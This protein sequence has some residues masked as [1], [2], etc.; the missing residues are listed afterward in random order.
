[1]PECGTFTESVPDGNFRDGVHI[2]VPAQKYHPVFRGQGAQKGV[3]EHS[4]LLSVPLPLP[5]G[6]RDAQLHFLGQTDHLSLALGGVL[7]VQPVQGEIPADFGKIGEKMLGSAGRNRIPGFQI[8][9]ADAF[10]R[11]LTAAQ[12]AVCQ[13]V[14][15]PSVGVVGVT[16]GVLIPGQ[17]QRNDLHV[18]HRGSPHSF[19]VPH[20]NRRIPKGKTHTQ[21]KNMDYF[22]IISHFTGKRKGVPA[23][24]QPR[25]SSWGAPWAFRTDYDILYESGAV[26]RKCCCSIFMPLK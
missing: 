20:P 4:Q 14:Q 24:E 1:M 12:N 15:P 13:V 11:I 3:Q 21:K 9:V 2:P 19:F 8:G 5:L 17:E 7:P 10:L 6:I 26:I 16:D 25:A 18:F 23:K 22:L